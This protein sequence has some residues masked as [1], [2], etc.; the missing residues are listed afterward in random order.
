MPSSRQTVRRIVSKLRRRN[1]EPDDTTTTSR[2]SSIT[3]VNDG[4]VQATASDA[5]VDA[6]VVSQG[7]APTLPPL[8]K[9]YI[10][11][12][13]WYDQGEHYNTAYSFKVE[14]LT[15]LALVSGPSTAD[16]AAMRERVH[17]FGLN[18]SD[19]FSRSL[20]IHGVD[21]ACVMAQ[22]TLKRAEAESRFT[23]GPIMFSKRG[24]D[25]HGNP[26][27]G[28]STPLQSE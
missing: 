19:W 2:A 14:D 11:V 23:A 5:E 12:T 15:P 28:P 3:L 1:G 26:M 13:N 16:L 20:R 21:G 18:V 24:T 6:E 10:S 7:S 4:R 17:D 25:I 8:F 22:D 9:G 27:T